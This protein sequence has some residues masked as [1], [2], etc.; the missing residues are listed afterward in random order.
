MSRSR[1]TIKRR[2][3]R[4][5]ALAMLVILV[6]TSGFVY[7]RVEHALDRQLDRDLKAYNDVVTQ[8]VAR[9]TDIAD[10][11]PGEWYQV[12]DGS[13]QVEI[14]S[15]EVPLGRLLTTS[16]L[17][18]I[19]RD[20]SR[21]F[22]RGSLFSPGTSTLRVQATEVVTADG[23][24]TVAA[25][26]S[27]RARDEALRELLGQLALADVLAL[28]GASYV[29]Y[30]TAR[31]ALDPVERYRRAARAAGESGGARLPVQAG[32]DDELTRL[33]HTL[34]D[35]LDRLAAAT[36]REHQYLADASHELRSPLALL[37]AEVELALHQPRD[38]AYM[39][40]V[41]VSVAGEV[42][43]MTALANALLDL[44]EL[45][46]GVQSSTFTVD[47]AA[48]VRRSAERYASAFERDGRLL[49]VRAEPVTAR[50]SEPWIDVAVRNLLS[51][52]LLHGA[53][54]VT[55]EARAVEGNVTISVT[56]DGP[57]IEPDFRSAAFD[58]FTRGDVNRTT[59]GSGLGLSLVRSVAEAHD[60]DVTIEAS[61]LD[62][63]RYTRMTIRVP[64]R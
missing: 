49:E 53:G 13:G 18:E 20:G 45:E 58:R 5:V 60:G 43:R 2:L 12:Y 41:L 21:R 1:L 61:P 57:G 55:V 3:V 48:L 35:L 54:A 6:L 42:D 8:A 26:I 37:K 28:I 11:T 19:G 52:A 62:A 17:A 24:V 31:G 14:G 39:R 40:Q 63:S 46:S 44:E 15:T 16:V 33:G 36:E 51:N 64:R 47:V 50:L 22:D 30:R 56:D 27:R 7:W 38:A 10:Q 32:R 9:Q 23:K 59:R 4:N 25:A 34:N 29:G